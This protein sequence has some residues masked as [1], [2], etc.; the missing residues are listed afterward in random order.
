MKQNYI[1]IG[2]FLAQFTG[3]IIM[4]YF[5]LPDFQ[6]III[7]EFLYFDLSYLDKYF[8]LVF[9]IILIGVLV[10][11]S[12][13]KILDGTAKAWPYIIGALVGTKSGLKLYDR[14]KEG[15]NGSFGEVIPQ[16]LNLVV[17]LKKIKTKMIKIMIKTKMINLIKLLIQIQILKQLSQSHLILIKKMFKN[18]QNLKFNKFKINDKINNNSKSFVFTFLFNW[19]GIP[20]P[21]YNAEPIIGFAF[22]VFTLCFIALISFINILGYFSSLYIINKYD[23]N[24]KL[25]SYPWI[26]KIIRYFEK[27]SIVFIVIEV[28]FVILSLLFLVLLSLFILGVIIL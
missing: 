26:I 8:N 3:L 11:F 25:S 18:I 22:C 2:T 16:E 17:V 23:Y 15:K 24:F 27:S 1:L 6:N 4:V 28:I 9:N 12:G 14:V 13:K 20:I 19:F 5:L 10:S 7:F 21:D